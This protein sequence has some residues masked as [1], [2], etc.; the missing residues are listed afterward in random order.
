MGVLDQVV[1]RGV[2]SE[3]DMGDHVDAEGE[4]L[5]P[6]GLLELRQVLLALDVV[7]SLEVVVRCIEAL[8]PLPGHFLDMVFLGDEQLVLDVGGLVDLR[9]VLDLYGAAD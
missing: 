2:L 8:E 4:E 7:R 3:V 9:D 5:V 1:E 6:V